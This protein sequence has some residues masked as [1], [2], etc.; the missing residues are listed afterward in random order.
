MLSSYRTQAAAAPP[1]TAASAIAATMALLLPRE[2]RVGSTGSARSAREGLGERHGSGGGS[3]CRTGV[4]RR[5]G[6]RSSA[7][8]ARALSASS[9]STSASSGLSGSTRR[10]YL[11]RIDRRV[12]RSHPTSRLSL[13][14]RAGAGRRAERLGRFPQPGPNSTYAAS[15]PPTSRSLS[16][17]PKCQCPVPVAVA[18]KG[19]EAG[20]SH[21]G[22]VDRRVAALLEVAQQPARC[23]ARMPARILAS[24]QDHSQVA[25][26]RQRCRR[27]KFSPCRPAHFAEGRS[28]F[29]HP[30][31]LGWGR[32][33]GGS[34]RARP[35]AAPPHLLSLPGAGATGG[36][37]GRRRAG[38][39]AANRRR[40]GTRRVAGRGRRA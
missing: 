40:L 37:G 3:G 36:G 9:G 16:Q 12:P 28:G 5:A 13:C 1:S 34:K 7:S 11:A 26:S 32:L 20:R 27:R 25:R 10:A 29:W 2:R 8:C 24:D 21:C 30:R 14:A 15:S 23:H 38:R 4:G 35:T 19:G 33:M 39:D 6:P 31:R 17:G 18:V 22:L